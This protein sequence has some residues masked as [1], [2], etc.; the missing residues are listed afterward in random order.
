[1]NTDDS[2]AISEIDWSESSIYSVT[3]EYDGKGEAHISQ[4]AVRA[5]LSEKKE[6]IYQRCLTELQ[7][8]VVAVGGDRMAHM[9]L[10]G[11]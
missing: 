7:Y 10:S 5:F 6:V 3:Y 2:K 8:V 9:M 11:G 4:G 1:M